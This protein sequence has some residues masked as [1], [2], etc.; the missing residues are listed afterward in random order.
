M[1][2][3]GV[4]PLELIFIL[5][6]ALI[7]L[8]PGDMVKAGR[9][10]GR[11]LRKVVTS[12]TW[13][14]VQNT[15]RDLRRLPNTLIRQAGLEEE[16]KMIQEGLNLNNVQE[17]IQAEF[18]KLKEIQRETE[19]DISDWTTPPS[20]APSPA[21]ENTGGTKVEDQPLLDES[22]KPES[23]KDNM[24]GMENSIQGAEV[25]V[26]DEASTADVPAGETDST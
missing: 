8:G 11:V 9:T 24:D 7:V 12:D 22:E 25:E 21:E 26:T 13:R 2:I 4:G 14:M 19:A 16:A 1:D 17:E 15:S 18:D 6:I 10:I 5:I 3:L 20:I 23:A